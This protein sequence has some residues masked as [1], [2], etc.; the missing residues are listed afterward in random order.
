[1]QSIDGSPDMAKRHGARV[2]TIKPH[3]FVERVRNR[4][5]VEASGDWILYLDPDEFV[6]PGYGE[7]LR[8]LLERSQAAAYYV[9][10]RSVAY[11]R[12]VYYGDVQDAL[13][14]RRWLRRQDL[15]ATAQW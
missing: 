9:P 7:K 1:M 13:P 11:G 15:E 4:G 2:V 8:P 12:T 5:L 14:K 6:P 3:P 10:F